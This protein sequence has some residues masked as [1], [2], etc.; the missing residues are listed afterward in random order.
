VGRLNKM[1]CSIC[2]DKIKAEGGGQESNWSQRCITCKDSWVCGRCYN[3]WDCLPSCECYKVMPCVICRTPM[4]YSHFVRGF[5]EGTG[6]GWWD[7]RK[8]CK[9]EVV[10]YLFRRD[11]ETGEFK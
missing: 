10:K 5:N 1:E 11:Q 4:T 7:D 3:E 2:Y 9:T 8:L 6:A